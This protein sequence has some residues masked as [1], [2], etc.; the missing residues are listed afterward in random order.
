MVQTFYIVSLLVAVFSP[1]IT[2][3]FLFRPLFPPPQQRWNRQPA[4]FL[5]THAEEYLVYNA[6]GQPA[7]EPWSGCYIYGFHRPEVRDY[8]G[9]HCLNLTATGYVDGCGA[10]AS[11]QVRAETWP[12]NLTS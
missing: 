6:S 11:W 8:W 10:D 1:I 7:V 9:E 2:D 3:L 4:D 5:M 12:S